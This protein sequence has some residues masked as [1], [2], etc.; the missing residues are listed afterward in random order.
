MISSQLQ[1]AMESS[2][3]T[4]FTKMLRAAMKGDQEEAATQLEIYARTD[5]SIRTTRK[6][7]KLLRVA[8]AI[9]NARSEEGLMRIMDDE[10]G[11]RWVRLKSGEV[12]ITKYG[13]KGKR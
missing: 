8:K 5:S 10:F 2:E 1:H 13:K 9:R 7:N 3:G 11:F 4:P 6:R 12:R